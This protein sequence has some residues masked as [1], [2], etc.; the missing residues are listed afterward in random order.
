MKQSIKE[1]WENRARE[2]AGTPAATTN[3]IFLRE[4]EVNTISSML[5]QLELPS[6]SKLLDVGCGDGYSTLKIA[7]RMIALHFI[8]LDYSDNM[9]NIAQARLSSEQELQDRVSF[10]VGDVTQL[11]K[12]CGR[13][14]YE[15]VVSDRCLINLESP[16]SQ[17]HA[18]AQIAEH[19]KPNGYYIA[20]ENFVETHDL[21]NRGRLAV[22]LPEIPIRWHNLYFRENDFRRMAHPFFSDITFSDFSSSYYFATRIIYAAMCKMRGEEPDYKHEIH[23]LSIDLPWVGQFSPIRMALLRRKR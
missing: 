17:T 21:M 19:L 23:Q 9:I 13:A 8:G 1:H 16:E 2:Y 5:Q 7:R 11:S 4:L 18:I 22:G 20:I 14:L 10:S 15:V 12:S 3:D 6:G